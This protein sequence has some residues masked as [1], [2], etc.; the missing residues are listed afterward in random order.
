M[1]TAK[2]TLKEVREQTTRWVANQKAGTPT[3]PLPLPRPGIFILFAACRPG[4]CHRQPGRDITLR[5]VSGPGAPVRFRPRPRTLLR[6]GRPRPPERA[7]PYL[8]QGIR[9]LHASAVHNSC[10]KSTKDD[11]DP[12]SKRVV[13]CTTWQTFSNTL[14]C[15]IISLSA[16]RNKEANV[17]W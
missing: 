14:P 2:R 16:R 3:D 15:R 8:V 9:V 5:N 1:G 7:P 17:F 11:F 6:G 13:V 12:R 10:G 4:S